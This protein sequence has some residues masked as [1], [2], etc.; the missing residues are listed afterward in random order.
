M[1]LI[2][3]LSNSNSFSSYSKLLK[4]SLSLEENFNYTKEDFIWHQ[5]RNL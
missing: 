2:K 3:T 4:K 5:I 1:L